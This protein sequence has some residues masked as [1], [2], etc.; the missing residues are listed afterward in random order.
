MVTKANFLNGM[1]EISD[2]VGFSENTILK[3]KRC[4][5]GMPIC[6]T[7]GVWIGDPIKLEE[8]YRELAI[9]DGHILSH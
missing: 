2:F 8:F 9:G 6:K 5:P 3:H 1:K 7:G 4:Y